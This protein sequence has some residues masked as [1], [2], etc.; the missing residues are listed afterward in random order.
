MLNKNRKTKLY[1]LTLLTVFFVVVLFF[2]KNTVYADIVSR[3]NVNTLNN[4]SNSIYLDDDLIVSDNNIANYSEIKNQNNLSQDFQNKNSELNLLFVGDIMTDRAI[5]KNINSHGDVDKFVS[6]FL[7]DYKKEN[8]NYDYV[9]ANLE[10][11][12]TENKS[13]TL[14]EN[15]SYSKDLIFTFPTSTIE[16]LKL[17]N[18]KVVSLANNHTDNFYYKGF[19]DT[20][21][22]LDS[23]G[24]KYFGNPY[25][26]NSSV[27]NVK[28][29][30]LKEKL[31]NIVCEKKICIAFVGYHQFTKNNFAVIINKEIERLR[32]L[33]GDQSIDFIVVMPHWGEEY[34]KISN[35]TQK[36][37]AKKW[38]DAGADIVIGAHPHVIQDSEI[39]NGKYIYYSL[40]NYIFDQWFNAE[41]KK[42]LVVNFKFKKDTVNNQTIKNIELV[43]EIKAQL[44]KN[45]NKYILNIN[46]I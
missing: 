34:Q 16:I 33:E 23:V 27:L 14:L 29:S 6:N 19:L 37:Y 7:A 3:Q 9:I 42:G 38:I 5:R 10:G 11:P 41:V 36:T 18:I 45:G 44:E 12:I 31:S 32:A 22:F 30:V 43:K 25:N 13:K 1:F 4:I 46:K 26:D 28:N 35:T 15:G 8:Q 39:Y 17:L 40:G 20:K 2:I 24:I 21:K